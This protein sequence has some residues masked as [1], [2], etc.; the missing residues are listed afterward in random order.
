MISWKFS[1]RFWEY[2]FPISAIIFLYI[3]QWMNITNLT[4]STRLRGRSMNAVS[5]PRSP[6]ITAHYFLPCLFVL[7]CA[8]IPTGVPR[9]SL[10]MHNRNDCLVLQLTSW[11]PK[12]SEKYDH[13]ISLQ[14]ASLFQWLPRTE[15]S[16]H[17]CCA[18][19]DGVLCAFNDCLQG[20]I[21]V[22]QEEWF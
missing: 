1:S 22:G 8:L 16:S 5:L 4:Y 12:T 14:K 11:T 20:W 18:E 10:K 19:W 21:V 17:L 15:L 2:D 9:P 7:L 13:Y 3:M 6:V